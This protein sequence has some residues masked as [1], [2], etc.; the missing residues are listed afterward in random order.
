MALKIYGRE[1]EI[2]YYT[3]HLRKIT[4]NYL[5][6]ELD[7]HT[8]TPIDM[9]LLPENF[10]ELLSHPFISLLPTDIVILL[11]VYLVVVQLSRGDVFP[12][13]GAV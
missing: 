3:N 10:P 12:V 13:W 5:S 4:N 11:W 1:F 7:H 8:L 2:V 6:F 9:P